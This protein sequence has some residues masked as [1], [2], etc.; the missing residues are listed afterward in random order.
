M[1][2]GKTTERAAA[3][4]AVQ[5]AV[6]KSKPTPRDDAVSPAAKDKGVKAE[7][8]PKPKSGFSFGFGSK[9][10]PKVSGGAGGLVFQSVMLVGAAQCSAVRLT[11]L[12]TRPVGSV[13]LSRLMWVVVGR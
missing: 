13:R 5:M 8:K 12:R 7:A 3:V 2:A 10:R 9:A 4:G 1:R 6:K 11:R